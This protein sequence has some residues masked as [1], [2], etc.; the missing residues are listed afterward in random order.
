MIRSMT[1]FSRSEQTTDIGDFTWELRSV[2]HRYLDASIRVPEALRSIEPQIRSQLGAYVSRGKVE[3]GLRYQSAEA[4]ERIELDTDKISQ[5][6][7]ACADLSELPNAPEFASITALDILRWPNIQ[8]K[9]EGPSRDNLAE[10]ALSLLEIALQDLKETREREGSKL[11]ALLIERLD[12]ME[13]ISAQVA[14]EMPEILEA[15]KQKLLIKLVE[16]KDELDPTRVEQ[17]IVLAA[18][19]ID[20]DEELDRLAAHIQE[21][22][23]VLNRDEP[24]GRRLDFL[25]QELNREANTLSSKS[26]SANNTRSA[27][28]LKVLIEQMREQ[29]QN[30]E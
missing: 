11:K 8:L 14:Q 30:I 24:V 7:T 10:H 6:F 4:V 26:I 18:Q 20:V 5:L 22:R 1:A 29:V 21:V 17:E 27:V 12:K 16:F 2:N 13:Q 19:K 3:L 28:D 23:E 15:L 25:M 9:A